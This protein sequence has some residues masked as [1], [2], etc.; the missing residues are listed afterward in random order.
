MFVCDDKVFVQ[1]PILFP[2]TKGAAE[3]R[4]E[5]YSRDK[6]NMFSVLLLR[7]SEFHRQSEYE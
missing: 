7:A 4:V 1:S 6:E 3:E 5:T 2:A